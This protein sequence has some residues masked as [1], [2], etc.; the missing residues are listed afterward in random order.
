[1]AKQ[2][3][4]TGTA[5]NTG[6]GDALRIAFTKANQNFAELYTAVE[7]IPTNTN[8]LTNGS[9]FITAS[10][11]SGYAL[12]SQIP[13]VSNFITLGDIPPIPA[14]VSD[15]T[16]MQGLLGQGGGNIFDENG[17]LQLPEGGSIAEGVVTENPTIELTPANPEVESQK[18]II[19]GGFGGFFNSENGITIATY[20]LRVTSGNNT[21]FEVYSQYPGETFYWWVD[22]YSPGQEFS[23]DN[24]Q[25]TFD[26]FGYANIVFTVNDD[27]VPLRIYVA[28]T[29]YNAYQNNK[30][31]VSVTINEAVVPDLYHLHLTTGDLQETS[32]FLGTDEHNVRTKIDG[33]IDLTSYDYDAESIYR[34]NFKNNVLRISSTNNEGDED[35][36]IKAED[37]LYLDALDDD[38]HIR[39]SDDI[40]LRPG[41]DFADDNVGYE[42][43]FT[44]GGTLIFYNGN[45]GNDYGYIRM[46]SDGEGGLRNLAFEGDQNVVIATDNENHSWTFDRDGDLTLPR[47]TGKINA[48]VS[49]GIGLQVE[50]TLDFEIKV[51]DGQGGANIWS[52]AG[53]DITF[54]DGT[55]Q[56]T[57]Y[58]GV[59]ADIVNNTSA[60]IRV[61]S[62]SYEVEFI[63][64]VSNGFGDAPG[65]TLTVTEIING[66]ITDG[67]T[68]YGNGL[69]EEGWTLTFSSDIMEPQG[70]GGPGNYLLNG[71]NY[72]TPSQSFNN[73][74]FVDTK[75][76]SFGLDGV[77]TL[78]EGGDIKD[79]TGV[80]QTAN[81]AEGEWSIPPGTNQ[82]GF[83]VPP[84]GTYTMWVRANIP[85]GILVWNAT[86]TVTN[87]NVPAI[88][89]QF[90]WNYTDGGSPLIL[91]SLPNQIRGTAGAISTDGTYAGTTSNRFVFDITNNTQAPQTVYWGYTKV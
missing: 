62:N 11:L 82:V 31:A 22:G 59:I 73:S 26:E 74:V 76:W 15:L 10:A 68:I 36:Y 51:N 63:G 79:H 87:A 50:A 23:P 70:S 56:T 83:E 25:I 64:R 54:P 43:R 27:T 16:D 42:L 40:R 41:Y 84:N 55:V 34:L 17:V 37:D 75:V 61:G 2:T 52:F 48:S 67:M 90:A 14:D 85:N 45:E 46:Y 47:G 13:D 38:I 88:G 44:D 91:T 72:L 21:Y 20:N 81:R 35:L 9:G 30:G 60:E 32:I 86:A 4:N 65:A 71:A 78:P 1:M 39:A 80:S 5:P 12:T 69:P 19:K 29:L 7:G 24:G 77:L 6:T 57:A 53:N 33:S 49:D 18:L 89:Q 66:T 58:T 28:D 8:Q 3:I